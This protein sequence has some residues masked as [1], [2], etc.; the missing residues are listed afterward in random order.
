MIDKIP[1]NFQDKCSVVGD[2]MADVNISENNKLGIS[3]NQ[4]KVGL[5]PHKKGI[6]GCY[7]YSGGS[8]LQ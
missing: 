3:N 7:C 4:I 5:L 2:L 6:I 8:R 1:T